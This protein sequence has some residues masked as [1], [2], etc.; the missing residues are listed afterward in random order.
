MAMS[1]SLSMEF[2]HAA[3][4]SFLCSHQVNNISLYL[5]MFLLE[6]SL[7]KQVISFGS[8]SEDS[9]RPR[10]SNKYEPMP[11]DSL[12]QHWELESGSSDADS[13][14][15]NGDLNTRISKPNASTNWM[16]GA[17]FRSSFPNDAIEVNSDQEEEVIS[18]DKRGRKKQ[19]RSS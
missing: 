1:L 8:D 2:L 6:I 18:T 15:A 3:K 7:G 16:Q 19:T 5:S 11:V 13:G 9:P 10:T 12:E 4:I 14:E 17:S